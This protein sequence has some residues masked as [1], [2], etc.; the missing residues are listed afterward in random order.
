MSPD[1]NT[2]LPEDIFRVVFEKSPGSILVK[3]DMPRFTILAASDSY[4][5]VTSSSRD[6]IVGKGFFEAF[7]ED[8]TVEHDE[9]AARKIFTR[10][11]ETGQKIDVPT[12]KYDIYDP[13]TGQRE[14]HFWSC[15]NIPVT[16]EQGQIAYIL[17]TVTDITEEVKAKEEAIESENRLRMATEATGLATWE[18]DTATGSF[19]YTPRMAEIFGY[20]ADAKPTLNEI[21]SHITDEDMDQ[22]VRPS[23]RRAFE[24]G[25]HFMR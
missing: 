4:L 9:T 6:R 15:S 3:A 1:V 18:L 24:T 12:Y 7:P 17:N 8:E 21:R 25:E 23:H 16:D 5:K 11:I 13:G 20:S 14:P 19:I 10:V 22:I 2:S